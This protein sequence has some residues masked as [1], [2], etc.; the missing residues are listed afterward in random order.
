MKSSHPGYLN[1]LLAAVRN[2]VAECLGWTTGCKLWLHRFEECGNSEARRGGRAMAI[3]VTV[4]STIGRPAGTACFTPGTDQVLH[5]LRG[6]YRRDPAQVRALS[7][8]SASCAAAAIRSGRSSASSSSS[9]KAA[10]PLSP[11]RRCQLVEGQPE[12]KLGVIAKTR[13][14]PADCRSVRGASRRAKACCGRFQRAQ[15]GRRLTA[16]RRPTSCARR[17]A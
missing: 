11:A 1:S 16:C 13:E 7:W 14:H 2:D 17:R 8:S 6:G 4:G 9:R 10:S 15:R 5:A 3:F 12:R